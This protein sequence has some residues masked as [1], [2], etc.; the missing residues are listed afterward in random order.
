VTWGVITFPGSNCDRDCVHVLRAVLGQR[1]EEVWHEDRSLDGL[2]VVVLPGGFAYGDYLRAGAIAATAPV[3]G[4]L[5]AF[6]GAGRPVLG[7]CNGFQILTETRLL[8]G[9]LLRN[10]TLRFRC[11]PVCV[12]VESAATPFTA[13]IP[14]GTV[15]TMP[16]AHGEGGFYAPL[17]D[18]AEIERGGRVVFRYCDARGRVSR[19]ANPNGSAASIAGVANARGNVVA[20]MPHPERA[21]EALLGSAD[22][23]RIFES[24]IAWL[25][26]RATTAAP[27]RAAVEAPR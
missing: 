24:A 7:I 8:P 22:G 9:T 27:G 6:A 11:R 2:D 10:A 13:A 3:I 4:A 23:R 25:G 1:V 5:R 14:E 20:L 12:R 17:D 19:E 26:A 18:L 21:S 15:L 16:I